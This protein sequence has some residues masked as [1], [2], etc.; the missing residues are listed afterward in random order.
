MSTFN[1]FEQTNTN[2]QQSTEKAPSTL[3]SFTPAYFDSLIKILSL[4]EKSADT[5][6]I[7]QSTIIQ[8]YGAAIVYA[9]ISN[10]FNG[11]AIDLEIVQPKK[12]I[13][14]FKQFR[15]NTDIDVIDDSENNRY[16]ITNNEIKLFLPKP[17]QT[18]TDDTLLPDFEGSTSYYQVKLDKETSK[19]LIGLSSES[20]FVE[21]LIQ[22][23]KFKGVHIA[24]TAIY[25]FNDY[26]KDPNVSKLD[27]TTADPMLR[28][29][30]FLSIAAEDYEINIGKLSNGNYFSITDCNTGFIH[31]NIYETLEVTTGGNVLI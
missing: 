13:K 15:N 23:E 21:F 24:D 22:D 11:T 3:I 1:P 19:Q 31:V 4:F 26:L 28:C 5:I 17:A 18:T 9:D 16:I 29:G 6:K 14:L 25:L 30:N 10:V 12:Y 2:L 8:K 7:S 27:E 20:K